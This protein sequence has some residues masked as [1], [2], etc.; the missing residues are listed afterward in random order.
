MLK[1]E[2]PH[3]L[4][5]HIAQ[6]YPEITEKMALESMEILLEQMKSALARGNRIEIRGFGSF[7]L[8]HHA[9]RQARNPRT[10]KSVQTKARYRVRFKPGK[11]LRDRLLHNP[12]TT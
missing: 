12:L 3:F 7:N 1:S 5:S 4:A 2:L 11:P 9:P 10:G 8:R 6:H